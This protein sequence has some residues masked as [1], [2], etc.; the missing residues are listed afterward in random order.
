[1]DITKLEEAR[2]L[3]IK[4]INDN[5]PNVD[6]RKGTVIH[7]LL[8]SMAALGYAS[9]SED[10]ATFEE[11]M[12]LQQIM[13]DPAS[14]DESVVDGILSN[15]YISRKLGGKAKGLVKLEVSE[16]RTYFVDANSLFQ[17]VDGLNYYT[18]ESYSI[19]PENLYQQDENYY[20]FVEV[21]AEEVGS[22]YVIAATTALQTSILSGSLVAAEAFNDFDG[23]IDQES[24]QELLERA[25][26]SLGA[27]AL[28]SRQ[29]ISTILQ[30]QFP[31][32][33][34]IT[35][36]G[37]NDRE[38]QR[39]KNNVGF[40]I[41]GKADIYVRT[42]IEP[43]T[44]TIEKTTDANGKFTLTS[45][46]DGEVP[47][48]RI[49]NIAL[50]SNPLNIT[51][52]FTVTTIGFQDPHLYRFSIYEQL[53]VETSYIEEDLIITADYIPYIQSI[54]EYVDGEETKY[55]RS[56]TLVRSYMPC[57]ISMTIN[58]R[59]SF[60]TSEIE[61]Q[62]KSTL[63]EFIN[64]YDQDILYVSKIMDELHNLDII[65]VNL[66]LEITGTFYLPDGD[67]TSQTSENK[68]QIESDF[69]LGI[70]E[71]TYRFF[72]VPS[73]IGLNKLV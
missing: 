61:P 13:D 22:N 12:Y 6:T 2:T 15:F 43:L 55:I 32:V 42:I 27:R 65:N 53:E 68:I 19:L 73:D 38:M 30:E 10:I 62:I 4:L 71:K 54:Q 1:M 69:N 24:N 60:P 41:G 3:M 70:S 7:D 67:I 28:S 45:L 51:T 11:K 31:E 34:Q 63:I 39:D 37:Y 35:V 64:T 23:G 66:P 5:Y 26:I 40:K 56:D 14:A 57:F 44:K 29:S 48:L 9:I 18:T 33:R 36:I 52:D 17:T 8:I 20:F 16:S 25:P 59:S 49:R 58:Y 50:A 21:Q 46:D 47:I 72:I